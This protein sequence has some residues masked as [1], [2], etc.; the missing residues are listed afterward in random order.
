MDINVLN[1]FYSKNKKYVFSLNNW[2]NIKNKNFTLKSALSF[3]LEYYNYNYK[4]IIDFIER[5]TNYGPKYGRR[6]HL[7]ND[8]ETPV[9]DLIYDDGGFKLIDNNIRNDEYSGYKVKH[10]TGPFTKKGVLNKQYQ[11]S[12]ELF[13]EVG[14]FLRK[15]YP[16]DGKQT[17]YE[18][19][20]TIRNFA[21]KN[22][23]SYKDVCELIKNK[24]LSFFDE[25]LGYSL[26]RESYSPKKIIV[27]EEW[28]NLYLN[29]NNQ[30]TYFSFLVNIKDFIKDLLLN[31]SKA[32]VPSDLKK[33]GL[34]KN[35]LIDFL[36][37][38]NIV[39]KDEKIV[40]KDENG[41]IESP[42]LITKFKVPYKNLNRKIRKLYIKLFEKNVVQK[43]EEDGEGATNCSSSGQFSQPLFSVQRRKFN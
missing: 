40:D 7:Y 42:K 36:I 6:G 11:K 31:P 41:N 3:L 8:Y 34:Y 2:I 10:I 23:I 37:R 33:C 29:E 4:S 24:K 9:I 20:K 1:D 39:I 15:M 43:I 17:L 16:N 18:K 28:Y 12:E 35:K 5:L 22:K 26:K 13:S 32:T 38:N 19:L 27:N 30:I 14:E 25:N 21:Q